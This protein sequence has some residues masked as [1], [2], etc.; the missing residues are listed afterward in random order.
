MEHILRFSA[1]VGVAILASCASTQEWYEGENLVQPLPIPGAGWQVKRLVNDQ[2]KMEMVRWSKT[3]GSGSELL[4]VVVAHGQRNTNVEIA[5]EDLDRQ[6]RS[7][8]ST[9]ST[10]LQDKA[11]ENGY[12]TI[13]WKTSCKLRGD[14]TEVVI[15]HKAI[16]GEDSFYEVQKIWRGRFSGESLREWS[17]H[18]KRV[19]LCNTRGS[20]HPC[21]E[22]F[23]RV[24]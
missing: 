1:A 22:G 17:D 13:T 12:N 10:D 7:H 15:L 24:Q 6:G 2:A 18:L 11:R 3:T 20:Q 16:S 19:K 23:K 8:C 5:R 4:Q 14:N 9:Y 21:P